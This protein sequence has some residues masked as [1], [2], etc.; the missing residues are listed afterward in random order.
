[1]KNYTILVLVLGLLA[2]T[3]HQA[4]IGVRNLLKS[5]ALEFLRVHHFEFIYSDRGTGSDRDLSIWR[6]DEYP[7]EY[8]SV[9]DLPVPGYDVPPTT[10][11]VVRELEEGALAKPVRYD[12]VW[13]DNGSGGVFDVK[14]WWPVPPEGYICI[15]DVAV[16]SYV[17]DPSTNWIRCLRE[18]LVGTANSRLIWNDKGSGA[19]KDVSVWEAVPSEEETFPVETMIAVKGY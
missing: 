3:S 18:D 15:G 8:H 9:G 7:L 1:M 12:L 2:S 5:P 4:T 10:G 14:F 11:Y 17:L 13:K 6:P 19:D 16:A